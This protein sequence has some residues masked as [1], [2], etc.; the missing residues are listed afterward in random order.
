MLLDFGTCPRALCTLLC[1]ALLRLKRYR[2]EA[3]MGISLNYISRGAGWAAT[4]F[5]AR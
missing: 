3:W 1:S 2:G 4:K 5:F